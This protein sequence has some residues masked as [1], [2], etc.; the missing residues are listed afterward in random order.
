MPGG[1]PW[2]PL[3]VNRIR[4]VQ[5]PQGDRTSYSY[6]GANRRTLKNMANGTRPTTGGAKSEPMK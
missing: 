4:E 3:S 2:V 6:D 1:P 5:N